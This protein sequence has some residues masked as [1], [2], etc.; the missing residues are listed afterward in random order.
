MPTGKLDF[1]KQAKSKVASIT[2]HK[3]NGGQNKIPTQKLDFRDKAKSRVGSLDNAQ[4]VPKGGNVR[5][6]CYDEQIIYAQCTPLQIIS[7]VQK[8]EQTQS[9]AHKESND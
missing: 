5:V 6:S 7:F 4:H 8:D 1:N 2:D 3:P 9:V